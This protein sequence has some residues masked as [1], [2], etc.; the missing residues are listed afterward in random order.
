MS[1]ASLH[2]ISPSGAIMSRIYDAVRGL[3]EV[4]AVNSLNS[5]TS[6]YDRGT[7]DL[8]AGRQTGSIVGVPVRSSPPVPENQADAAHGRDERRK[9]K[10]AAMSVGV[11]V[12]PTN[13]KD[14]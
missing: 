7:V 4:H 1:S 2:P 11:H 12:R 8:S 10:R 6:G 5:S 9:Q 3:E 13:I 14:G